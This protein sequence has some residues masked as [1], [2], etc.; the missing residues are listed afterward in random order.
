M[1]MPDQERTVYVGGTVLPLNGGET[2]CEALVVEGG[3]VLGLGTKDEMLTLAGRSA[4]RI[5]LQ[6][7]TLMPG[8]VDAHPHMLHFGALEC[9]LVNL[10]DA[11]S[12]DDIVTRIRERAAITPPGEWILAT[13]IG[14]PHYFLRRS[15]RDLAEGRMPDRAV[16]D[17]A[18]MAHP[19]FIQAWAPVTP[20]TCAFNSAGLERVGLSH[21]TPPR[22]CG[23][24]IEKDDDGRPTGILRGKV[25][26]YYCDDP[27]WLQIASKFPPPPA[28]LWEFGARY[29]QADFARMGVT[30]LYEA[31]CMEAEH[32]AAYQKLASGGELT[33]RVVAGLELFNSPFQPHLDPTSEMLEQRLALAL[34]L[35][36]SNHDQVR[37]DG[38]TLSRGGPCWPG[39][40]RQHEPYRGP[41][42]LPTRGHTFVP[43]WTEPR[44]VSYCLDHDLRF[45]MVLGG[46]RDH[47]DFLASLSAVDRQADIARRHWV[48]QHSIL[49][50]RE[51]IERYR[52][53]DFEMTTSVGFAWGKGDMYGERM[54]RNVWPHLIP[55]RRM[56]DSGLNVC[57]GRDWGPNSRFEH[58]ALAQSVEFC[59]SGR[60][61]DTPDHAVTREQA[62]ATWT[63]NG[64]RLMQWEGLGSL[65]AGGLADLIVV[66]RDPLSC[67]LDELRATE[68]MQTMFNGRIVW[69]SGVL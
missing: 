11:R 25:N 66:D 7:A 5:A 36:D 2:R 43:Q 10:L 67:T 35:K 6:G 8:L 64:A 14:E 15:Y 29:A 30:A 60:R 1:S 61:N 21:A 44:C 3:R 59:G 65:A 31:H 39:F 51:H 9:G 41:D 56:L 55:L 16:L 42:G 13:P 24:E 45:N 47:D 48:L 20:N 18:T 19:V 17:R 68:V 63:T 32:I 57:C 38:V 53:Y 22:V 52:D 58:M 40:L 12:H 4:R 46:L 50:G 69:D 34:S 54:G 37:V 49:I 26:N 62:L 27:F 33:V 28:A 23:V